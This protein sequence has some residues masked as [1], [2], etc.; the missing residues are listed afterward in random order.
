[1]SSLL[2]PQ[3]VYLKL[4]EEVQIMEKNLI[5]KINGKVLLS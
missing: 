3:A 2:H 5:L 1:M 4:E